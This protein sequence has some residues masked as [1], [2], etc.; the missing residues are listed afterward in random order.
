MARFLIVLLPCAL[1]FVP[2]SPSPAGARAGVARAA[3]GKDR[4]FIPPSA[5]K[6]YEQIAQRREQIARGDADS[7]F[8]DD[9]SALAATTGFGHE[10]KASATQSYEQPPSS[11]EQP[12]T[13]QRGAIVPPPMS[14]SPSVGNGVPSARK[15]TESQLIGG[16]QPIGSP[17]QFHGPVGEW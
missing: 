15:L 14:S 5:D 4:S 8:V 1:G 17:G 6:Y 3:G 13:A 11:V 12:P 7:G 9:A 10:K 16:I 2:G